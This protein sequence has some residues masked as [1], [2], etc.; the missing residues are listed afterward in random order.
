MKDKNKNIRNEDWKDRNDQDLRKDVNRKEEMPERG[1]S[2]EQDKHKIAN[3][4]KSGRSNTEG[5]TSNNMSTGG[6]VNSRTSRQRTSV[7]HQKT[8]IS[9]TDDDGQSV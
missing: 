2:K 7:P 1:T 3:V 4:P 5:S 9:G 8:F 6:L